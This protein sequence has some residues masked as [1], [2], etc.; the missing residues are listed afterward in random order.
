MGGWGSEQPWRATR[1]C[2]YAGRKEWWMADQQHSAPGTGRSRPSRRRI[3]CPLHPETRL[4]SVSAKLSLFTTE[5]G[6]LI[7]RGHGRATAANLMLAYRQVVPL[8]NEWLEGFWC[9]DCQQ[10]RWWH[11]QRHDRVRHTLRPVAPGLWQQAAGVIHP[12]GNPTVSDFSRRAARANGIHGLKQF[13][14][15]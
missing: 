13:G 10:T 6:D 2:G 5:L 11:V 7:V 12:R 4:L 14:T 8:H 15:I 1:A 3:H 9:D